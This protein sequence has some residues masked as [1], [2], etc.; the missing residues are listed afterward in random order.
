[1]RRWCSI[2]QRKLGRWAILG[3]VCA[4]VLNIAATVLLTR[5]SIAN[6]PG[7]DALARLNERYADS[8]HGK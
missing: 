5:A 6:Y 2:G 7:G 1:M 8:P 3:V 4:L